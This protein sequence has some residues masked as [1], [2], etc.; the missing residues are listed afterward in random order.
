VAFRQDGP[1]VTL[2]I[3]GISNLQLADADRTNMMAFDTGPGNVMIDHIVEARTGR[4]YDKD[5]ELAAKGQVI[6]ELLG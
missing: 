5:D 4:G 3:G 2:N 6:P 1:T